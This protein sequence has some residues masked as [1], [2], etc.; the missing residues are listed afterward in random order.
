MAYQ[1][2]Y[3]G[4]EVEAMLDG[5]SGKADKLKRVEWS[6][7]RV[8]KPNV[9]QN[10]VTDP[11]GIDLA[12]DAQGKEFFV[13]RKGTEYYGNWYF[14]N[15]GTYADDWQEGLGAVAKFLPDVLY[16]SGTEELVASPDRN[17]LVHVSNGVNARVW[18]FREVQRLTTSS[19]KSDIA[20]ALG[21]ASVEDLRKLMKTHVF[22]NVS[23][24]ASE[25]NVG[26]CVYSPCLVEYDYN[27]EYIQ[28]AVDS[29]TS[30]T[31]II[32]DQMNNTDAVDSVIDLNLRIPKPIDNLTSTSKDAPLSANMGRTLKLDVDTLKSWK[33]TTES[34]KSTINSWKSTMSS[35]KTTT[36]SWKNTMSTWKSNI[37][38]WKNKIPEFVCVP[39]RG[40]S[41]GQATPDESK[42]DSGMMAIYWVRP[43]WQYGSEVSSPIIGLYNSMLMERDVPVMMGNGTKL[44]VSVGG[45]ND[46]A[47]GFQV[48]NAQ[49]ADVTNSY[50]LWG[51]VFG[52][53]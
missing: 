50:R 46:Y 28:I 15:E 31:I 40:M 35:W 11:D 4:M 47:N 12:T 18:V 13:A 19:T 41:K 8:A 33:N 34:W 21:V 5:L 42:V 9:K 6:G 10:S 48:K 52:I 20:K 30:R 16:V 36:D 39:I 22:V 27:N 45:M 1:S 53:R 14:R 44:T 2:K 25:E 3:K 51:I 7:R 49:G 43:T 38:T 32:F 26:N 17:S 29:M 23:E 37:D 24:N